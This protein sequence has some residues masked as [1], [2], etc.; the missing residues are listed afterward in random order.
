MVHTY[1][2]WASCRPTRRSNSGGCVFR[3]RYLLHH[4]CRVQAR[5]SLSTCAV[6]LHAQLQSLQELLSLKQIVEELQCVAKVDSIACT[7]IMLRHGVGQFKH[8]A[9]P[10]MWAQQILQQDS[11]SGTEDLTYRDFC[12]LSRVSQLVLRSLSSSR[13]NGWNVAWSA[14][15]RLH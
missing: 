1:I 12:R 13:S 5:V 11:F 2:G 6:W 3:G 10:T 7:G 14:V 4:W 15:R 9:T 8:L